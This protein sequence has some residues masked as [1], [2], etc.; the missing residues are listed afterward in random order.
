MWS[1]RRESGSAENLGAAGSRGRHGGPDR[2][3]EAVRG[4]SR[5]EMMRRQKGQSTRGTAN[6]Q[7]SLTVGRRSSHNEASHRRRA[8]PWY[9]F[10][11][12]SEHAPH[13]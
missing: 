10:S 4:Q 2:L 7:K 12:A 3:G 6:K 8:F 11:H 1:C 9:G 13:A 5:A